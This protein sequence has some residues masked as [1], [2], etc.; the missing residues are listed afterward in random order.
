MPALLALFG[1]A[2]AW[3]ALTLVYGAVAVLG[4]GPAQ[5]ASGAVM[6]ALVL[7]VL[8]NSTLVLSERGS[9]G[10]A[11]KGLWAVAALID[12]G[13]TYVAHRELLVGGR[14]EL[15]ERG[16]IIGLTVMVVGAPA[17]FSLLFRRWRHAGEQLP[18]A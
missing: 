6:M 7:G 18:P 13:C 2:T 17:F 15:N 8:L 16:L 3:N 10:T 4:S 9:L 1:L 5:W 12:L 11:L 14:P